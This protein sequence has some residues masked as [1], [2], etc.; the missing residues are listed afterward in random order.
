MDVWITIENKAHVYSYFSF[1]KSTATFKDCEVY[2]A[3]FFVS[4]CC[5]DSVIF[6]LAPKNENR[7]NASYIA[8]YICQWKMTP[9]LNKV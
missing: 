7:T 6:H 1:V 9:S 4:A 8:T 3:F 2:T 5:S